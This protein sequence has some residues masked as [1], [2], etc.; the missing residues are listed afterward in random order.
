MVDNYFEDIISQSE[1][2]YA[3]KREE[4]FVFDRTQGYSIKL[5]LRHLLC[6]LTGRQYHCPVTHMIVVQ[7]NLGSM[8]GNI[9]P[10]PRARSSAG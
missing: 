8:R 5:L 10:V 2:P 6:S 9:A 4:Y 1:E 7:L 3:R